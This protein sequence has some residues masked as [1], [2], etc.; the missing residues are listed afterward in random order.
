MTASADELGDVAAVY[1]ETAN[2]RRAAEVLQSALAQDPNNAVL[3]ARYAQACLGLKDPWR[4]AHAAYAALGAPDN[5][6]AMRLYTLALR[7]LGRLDEARWMAWRNVMEHPDNYRAHYL[8]AEMLRATGFKTNALTEVNEALRLNPNSADALV[9]RGDIQREFWGK[10]AAEAD[11]GAALQL[12]PDHAAAVHNLAISR[13]R[14]GSLTAAVRGFLGAG[15][16]DPDLG[17][18]ARRNVGVVLIRVLRLATAVAGLLAVALIVVM[19]RH[20]SAL[21]TLVPRIFAAILTAGLI[22]AIAWIVRSV[23]RPV[24]RAVLR[25]RALLGARLVFVSVAALAGIVVVLVGSTSVTDVFGS[26]LLLG[27]I[28]LTML[29]WLVGQ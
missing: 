15:Q 29:G 11:Y 27:T 7:G 28:G 23:P 9:L 21:S 26:L 14:W 24:L 19:A 25:E 3:L 20:E 12:E 10:A 5:E 17:R 16:L 6:H 4:A 1:L 18:L 22:A 2:Y 8:Y 13:L